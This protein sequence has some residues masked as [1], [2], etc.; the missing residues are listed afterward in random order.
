[1]VRAAIAEP[2]RYYHD[3]HTIVLRKGLLLEQ[4]RHVLWHELV[5][6]DREDE[7][8]NTDWRVEA[9]VERE[10]AH[11]AMPLLA[12]EWAA[13][14]AQDWFEFVDLLKLPDEWVRF[15]MDIAHPA[16][17]RLVHDAAAGSFDF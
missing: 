9:S 11:R 13:G 2:G 6:A 12:L 15:R 17:T 8:C 5:H 14:A 4:E 16:E 10:A 3:D 1:M 7:Y